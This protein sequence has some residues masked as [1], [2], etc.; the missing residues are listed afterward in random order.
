[1]AAAEWPE[2]GRLVESR[3]GY[4]LRPGAHDVTL[5]DWKAYRD[6]ADRHLAR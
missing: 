4:L 2:P 1:M 5:A 3:I 6:F